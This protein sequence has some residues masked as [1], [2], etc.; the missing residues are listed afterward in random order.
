[1]NKLLREFISYILNEQVSDQDPV[2]PYVGTD[3]KQR[4]AKASTLANY[5]SDHPGRK[6]YDTWKASRATKPTPTEK[7]TGRVKKPRPDTV[8]KPSSSLPDVPQS[9]EVPMTD[10]P[11]RI[12]AAPIDPKSAKSDHT[13]LAKL[14][15]DM[16]SIPFDDDTHR[17]RAETFMKLWQ[18]FISAP[19]YEEQV[20]AVEALIEQ[21]LIQGT[22]GR[23]KIYIHTNVGFAPK[24]MCGSQGTAVTKLM[25]KII[26]ERGLDLQPRDGSSASAAAAESGPTNEA[27]VTA[28][29]DP[30]AANNS[31]YEEKKRR[32][33]EV[34]GNV[35]E[36]D[37]LNRDAAEAIRTS[38]P[39][40]AKI[41]SC[42]QVGGIGSTRLQQLGIDPLVDPTDI[43]LEYEVGG[44]KQTMKISAKIYTNPSRITMKNAGLE[45]AGTRYLGKPEGDSAD[46]LYKELRKKYS[47]NKPG[48]SEKDK[49]EAKRKF[50]QEYLTKYSEEMETLTKTEKGQKRLLSMWQNVHGCG[51]DVHT[52]IVNKGS[53]KSQLK[54]PDHYCNPKL[55][56]KVKYNGTKVVI[57]MDSEGP[58]TLEINLKTEASG[59]VKLLFNHVVRA[60]K[61]QKGK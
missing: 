29:L 9:A 40:G 25:Q 36:I 14:R 31:A 24:G 6:A 30:S 7:P 51:K 54:S 33:A 47:W 1:M 19:T 3:N 59:G 41:T 11:G 12:P 50:R 52:L 4:K 44:K 35:E 46:T 22:V 49:E 45:D 60:Q 32:Y 43:L 18:A 10:A 42:S 37:R 20:K 21:N 13:K 57:E 17:G 48:M 2:L 53:G 39:K 27:G 15:A 61:K 55:P 38:L 23:E 8:S 56:F 26:K 16:D 34:G 5:P 28:L 58:E